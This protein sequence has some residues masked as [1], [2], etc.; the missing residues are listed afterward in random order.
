MFTIH[1]YVRVRV[2]LTERRRELFT[3]K[4]CAGLLHRVEPHQKCHSSAICSCL[5]LC[6]CYSAA[7]FDTASSMPNKFAHKHKHLQ[8]LYTHATTHKHT[9]A[10]RQTDRQTNPQKDTD[11]I[12]SSRDSGGRK[13]LFLFVCLYIF[14]I[15]SF[16]L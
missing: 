11:K 5:K 7:S 16:W 2:Y 10:D 14:F 13:I 9:Q 6:N 8:R 15:N 4:S 1:V 12:C 3:Y